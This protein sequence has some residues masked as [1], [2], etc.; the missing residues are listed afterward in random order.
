M[1]L[2]AWE[3]YGKRRSNG[4][5]EINKVYDNV[6]S[7]IIATKSNDNAQAQAYGPLTSRLDEIA[8]NTKPKERVKIK[9]KPKQFSEEIDYKPEVDPYEDLDVEGLRDLDE[10]VL[11]G[12]SKQIPEDP[13]AYHYPEELDYGLNDS[14]LHIE[15]ADEDEEDKYY[16]SELKIVSYDE[17]Q[18]NLDKMEEE[19]A[20][21]K[22]MNT[23]LMQVIALAQHRSNQLSGYRSHVTRSLTKEKSVRQELN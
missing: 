14:D 8:K 3:D 5:Q 4:G 18:K 16:I 1:S 12:T 22:E 10:E 2:K 15:G 6:T 17:V 9:F 11:P 20:C 7:H 21:V 13:P 23:Y 19:G